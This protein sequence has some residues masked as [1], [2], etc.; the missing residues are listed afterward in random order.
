MVSD[1]FTA[2]LDALGAARDRIG[3]LTDELTGPPPDLPN[4]EVFGHDRL[5]AAVGTFAEREQE[6]RAALAEETAAIR[7]GLAETI[8]TYRAADEDGAGRF[9][10]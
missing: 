2:D 10:S 8:R 4:A 1:G 3:R 5:S 6:G 7:A 9:R